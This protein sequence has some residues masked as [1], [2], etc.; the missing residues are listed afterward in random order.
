MKTQ[1]RHELQ[2]NELADYLGTHLQRIQPYS[3][4]LMVGVIA[5]A[6]LLAGSVYYITKQRAKRGISWTDYFDAIGARDARSLEEVGK[7][8]N[9]TKAALWAQQSAGDIKLATGAGSLYSD[10]KEA[11]KSL[12]DAEKLYL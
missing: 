9:G 5:L 2:T 3:T 12:K 10:R 1:R 6:V 11:E 8:H 4:H 7:L